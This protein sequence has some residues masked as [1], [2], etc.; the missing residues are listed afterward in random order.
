M[1]IVLRIFFSISSKSS[2][3]DSCPKF[4]SILFTS[5]PPN[6]SKLDV[7]LISAKGRRLNKSKDFFLTGTYQGEKLKRTGLLDYIGES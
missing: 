6:P 3:V 1:S 2:V 5:T 7:I 4:F